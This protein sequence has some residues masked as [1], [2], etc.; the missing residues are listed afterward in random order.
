[1]SL[2]LYYQDKNTIINQLNKLWSY[3]KEELIEL[4]DHSYQSIKVSGGFVCSSGPN[5]TIEELMK[6]SDKALYEAKN[7]YKGHFIEYKGK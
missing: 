3:F 6:K 4:P 2:Y 5:N 1:M 7:H